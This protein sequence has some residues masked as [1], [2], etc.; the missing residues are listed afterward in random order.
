MITDNE[1]NV[2]FH[3]DL[4][5]SQIGTQTFER[6]R[7]ALE[8]HSVEFKVLTN[9]KDIWCRDYMPIQLKK[10]RFI[11]FRYEPSYLNGC[12]K[13]R[14]I[15]REVLKSNGQDS[16]RNSPIS[17]WTAVMLCDGKIK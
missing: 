5:E 8:L 1:C 10:N 15:P 6:I 7:E 2:V 3:S 9:T 14:S 4:L 11:Q 17:T 13:L 12:A 16:R